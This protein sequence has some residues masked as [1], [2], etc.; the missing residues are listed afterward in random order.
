MRDV[1]FADLLHPLFPFFL[2]FPEFA[3]AGDIAAIAFGGDVFGDRADRFAG[4]DFSADRC[5]DRNFEQLH[6]DH[7]DKLFANGAPFAFSFGAMDETRKSIDGLFID[8]DFQFDDIAVF[9]AVKF[10]VKRAIAAC[11][12]FELVVEIGDDFIQGKAIGKQQAGLRPSFLFSVALPV[13]PCP[14]S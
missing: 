12:R 14:G 7:F 3:F 13:F 4:N 11:D 2:L 1:D 9:I 8:A 6:R 10:V 5:L